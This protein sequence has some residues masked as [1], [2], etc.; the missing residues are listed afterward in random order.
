[1]NSQGENPLAAQNALAAQN[2]V[3]A[4]GVDFKIPGGANDEF[5]E[6]L[7][8]MAKIPSPAG[9]EDRVLAGVAAAPRGGRVLA[10]R[11]ALRGQRSWRRSAAAAAIVLVVG[12]GGWG[13]YSHVE[14]EQAARVVSM[15]ARVAQ[16]AGFSSAGVVRAPRTIPGPAIKSPAVRQ[17]AKAAV[18]KSKAATKARRRR[19]RAAGGRKHAVAA[20]PAAP[21]S[22]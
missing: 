11:G 7:R 16:P 1:M 2:P 19:A 6:T 8:L 13:V 15:P 4:A 21:Q 10:W 3:A 12:G 17:K 22:K 5:E 20:R 18:A 9:L 14:Q